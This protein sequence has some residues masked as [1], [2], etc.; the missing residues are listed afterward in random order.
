MTWL[1]PCQALRPP[2]AWALDAWAF[3]PARSRRKAGWRER[4]SRIPVTGLSWFFFFPAARTPGVPPPAA[5]STRRDGCP[6][7]DSVLPGGGPALVAGD[8]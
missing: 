3:R 7:K 8:P 1:S 5:R 6:V 4:E 2:D